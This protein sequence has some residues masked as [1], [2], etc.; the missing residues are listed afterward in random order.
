MRQWHLI[1]NIG[2]KNRIYSVSFTPNLFRVIV[3]GSFLL[4]GL[5]YLGFL[6][7]QGIKK[8]IDAHILA[9]LKKENNILSRK[10]VELKSKVDSLN[11]TFEKL[12]KVD[13]RLRVLAGM[14]FLSKD[15][16]EFGLGG[17]SLKDEDIEVLRSMGESEEVEDIKKISD[18]IS[19]LINATKF[20]KES[21]EK[22]KEV[23]HQKQH[24]RDR[25]PSIAPCA[26]FLGSGFGYRIDPFTRMVKM[27]HGVD[28][29][30]PIGTPIIATADGTVKYTGSRGGYGLCIEIDH[31]YGISTL[32]AHLSAILVEVGQFVRRGEVIGLL[33][34][35]GRSASPHLH[36]EVRV[37]GKPQNPLQYMLI[38][39]FEVD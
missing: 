4:F 34:N 28:I 2:S 27:H 23:L 31:G 38:Y 8:E 30:G 5:G 1:L 20:Q 24:I 18:K 10:Y 17:P 22:I 16:L 12:T 39:P 3:A 32:Y 36:Y 25:T 37:A 35:T 26:G 14:E 9:K 13:M 21:F 7:Y 11:K 29:G 19:W 6:I 15:A 33:G